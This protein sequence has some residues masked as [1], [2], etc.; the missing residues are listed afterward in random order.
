M[1]EHRNRV[2]ASPL[3]Y[4]LVL[5][6]MLAGGCSSTKIDV[7]P[8]TIEPARA[9]LSPRPATAP[10][11]QVLPLTGRPQ[12]ALTDAATGSLLVL[13][14]GADPKAA[15]TLAVVSR[16]G[17]VRPITLPGPATAAAGD[18]RGTVYAATRG[19]FFTIDT[20][21]GTATRTD[22]AGHSDTDF[23]AIARRADGR[24][25]LGDA[26]GVAYTLADDFTVAATA[27]IFARVDAI[28]TEG[29]TAVVLD[30]GQT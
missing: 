25:V 7:A 12:A 29:E 21:R 3:L 23:T 19:G 5:F 10:A 2:A 22:I 9:A 27:D 17:A 14:P 13:C 24:L 26:H 28:V 8:P 20:G 6:T 4:A 1:P 30:R 18:G 16:T 15:A 11:G